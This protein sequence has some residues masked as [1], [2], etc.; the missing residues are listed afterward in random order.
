MELITIDIIN[1][2]WIFKID[3]PRNVCSSSR[4]FP[5]CKIRTSST[6]ALLSGK[7]GTDSAKKSINSIFQHTKNN[8]QKNVSI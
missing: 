5:R 6:L 7:F 8:L 2:E 4:N 3:V 1:E